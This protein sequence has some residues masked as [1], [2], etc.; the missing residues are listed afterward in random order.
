MLSAVAM[1]PA[2]A[3][4]PAVQPADRTQTPQ[5]PKNRLANEAS[6]YLRQHQ[7]DPVDWYPWG[8]AALAKARQDDKPIFLSVGYSACHWCHVMAKE[9]FAD[10]EIAKLMNAHFVCIK[11]D[12]EERPDI[13]EIYMA[14]LQAMGQQGGW[15]MSVFLTPD[16]A[17]F[18]GGTYF[19]PKDG[20]GLPGF[21]RVL[22]RLR[23]AWAEQRPDITGSAKELA[24]HLRTALAP[25]LEPGEP[26]ATLLAAV[27]PAARGQFDTEHGG[28]APA[29][30]HAP[31]FPSPLLLQVL[32]RV[33][34]DAALPLVVPTLRAMANGGIHDQL[35]GGFHRY[36]TDRAWLVP[37]FEKM[38]YDNALLAPCYLEAAA[39]TGDASFAAVAERTLDWTLREMRDGAGGFW[40][41]TDAQS[42]G[43]EGKF[44]VWSRAEFDRVLGTDAALLADHFGV[45]TAGNWEHTNVLSVVRDAASLAKDHGGDVVA[46]ARKLAAGC[47]AL[48]ATR[49]TRVRPGTDDKVLAGW[50]GLQLAA[51]A[52]GYRA[53]GHDRYRLAARE[54]ATFL[55]QH[56]VRDG[57]TWR[58]FHGGKARHQGV[59]EDQAAVAAGLLALFEVDPDPRWLTAAHA[60]LQQ[61]V[62]HF[63]AQDGS[64]WSTA[65]DHE[66]LLARTK[67]AWDGSTPSGTA[68]VAQALLRGGVMLGDNALLD[69]GVGVLRANHRLL[70]DAP[71]AA[72]ALLR[73]V[74][75]HLAGPREVVVVGAPDDAR[76]RALLQ[77]AWRAFPDHHVVVHV[78]DGNRAALAKLCPWLADK[79]LVAGAPAA[80]VCRRGACAAPVTT[81]EALRGLL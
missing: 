63:R 36:A 29:P 74:Q 37:H 28:F 52:H 25:A 8:E 38:L 47:A 3:Q 76:T 18:F 50:N 43:V 40:S 4:D 5:G 72:P 12:R 35:A 67:V 7:H 49:G 30:Q 46:V 75:F 80:Y 78:H 56:L 61:T 34:G 51:L 58:A 60:I 20:N 1:G 32:L 48:L 33:P 65:D 69:H 14:A 22:E 77:A 62:Q 64:F 10:P 2:A 23:T 54:L 19:P 9:S 53:L 73:A 42:D 70:T 24:A 66:A 39:R 21:R 59:L 41:S 44:F 55:L 6:P 27:L 81:P 11:V 79:P 31:K 71:L 68:L 57:R 15:P 45:T 26:T 16:G 13:D 17:P